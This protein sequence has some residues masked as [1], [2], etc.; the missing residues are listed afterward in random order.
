MVAILNIFSAINSSRA[1][2]IKQAYLQVNLLRVATILSPQ[3]TLG[4]PSYSS[5]PSCV[6]ES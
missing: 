3:Y 2:K 1:C 4:I 5:F 6:I